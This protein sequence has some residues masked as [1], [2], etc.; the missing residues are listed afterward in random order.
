MKIPEADLE[1]SKME[2]NTF[3]IMSKAIKMLSCINF[4]TLL[5]LPEYIYLYQTKHSYRITAKVKY[6]GEHSLLRKEEVE[7]I[8]TPPFGKFAVPI[9]IPRAYVNIFLSL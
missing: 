8:H 3:H 1:G 5:D 2:S 7:L 9:L 6:G 4:A